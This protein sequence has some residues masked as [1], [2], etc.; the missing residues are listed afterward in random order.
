MSKTCR[1][2][3]SDQNSS[4]SISAAARAR[5]MRLEIGTD[6]ICILY[7]WLQR[8]MS[9]RVPGNIVVPYSFCANLH[10]I[11]EVISLQMYA[12]STKP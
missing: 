8:E 12:I 5:G 4:E 2:R 9:S 3:A 6:E 1:S 7:P 11:L 10:G